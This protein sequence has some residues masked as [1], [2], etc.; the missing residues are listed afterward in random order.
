MASPL[1]TLNAQNNDESLAG[2]KHDRVVFAVYLLEKFYDQIDL[3][4]F[5]PGKDSSLVILC[6]SFEINW[7]NTANEFIV[8]G[9]N[10]VFAHTPIPAAF[11]TVETVKIILSLYPSWNTVLVFESFPNGKIHEG[12]VTIYARDPNGG[13]SNGIEKYRIIAPTIKHEDWLNEKKK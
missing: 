13:K 4:K 3:K 8:V 11:T 10:V 2:A 9:G 5:D 1:G 7:A 6:H 12:L